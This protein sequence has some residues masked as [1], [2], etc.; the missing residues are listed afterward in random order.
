MN[1][2]LSELNVVLQ[3]NIRKELCNDENK[4]MKSNLIFKISLNVQILSNKYREDL[5]RIQKEILKRQ[6]RGLQA[7][8]GFNKFL[9]NHNKVTAI[10]Y[11]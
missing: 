11:N 7:G 10:L 3:K 9:I 4:T 1:V 8:V 5:K 6:Q 2:D